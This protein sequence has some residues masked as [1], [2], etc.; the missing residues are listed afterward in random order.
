MLGSIGS[1]R[2]LLQKSSQNTNVRKDKVEIPKCTK[3]EA[4][5]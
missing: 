3:I 2:Q 1:E 5:F 4:V